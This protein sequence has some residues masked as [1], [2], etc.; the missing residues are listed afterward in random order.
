MFRCLLVC[1]CSWQANATLQ[2]QIM[3]A[4]PAQSHYP[5]V[6]VRE[7]L[8]SLPSVSHSLKL[9][10]CILPIINERGVQ[11]KWASVQA[12]GASH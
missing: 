3:W 7:T 10:R 6:R 1:V 11:L 12:P 4:L 2:C 9:Y 8:N 5:S